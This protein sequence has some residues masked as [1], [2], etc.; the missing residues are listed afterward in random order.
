MSDMGPE[1][2]GAL[3]DEILALRVENQRLRSLLGL[4]EPNRHEVTEP[5]SSIRTGR[6]S[7]ATSTV[8][9]RVRARSPSSASC[10]LGARMSTPFA[11]RPRGPE[12]PA[13]AP[14]SWVAGRTRRNEV[15]RICHLTKEW[16]NR[17]S[18]VRVA[19]PPARDRHGPHSLECSADIGG[20]FGRSPAQRCDRLPAPRGTVRRPRSF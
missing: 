5:C 10:S 14:P 13:G 20:V 6:A 9:R 15:V 8:A 7:K 12:R 11:G 16:W 1:D 3:V 2:I 4:D 19:R 17:T 18:L